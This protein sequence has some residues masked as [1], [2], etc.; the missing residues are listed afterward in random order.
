[1]NGCDHVWGPDTNLIHPSC[2]WISSTTLLLRLKSSQVRADMRGPLNITG[3]LKLLD[4]PDNE[5]R[6]NVKWCWAEVVWRM[7]RHIPRSWS[8]LYFLMRRSKSSKILLRDIF[9]GRFLSFVCTPLDQCNMDK[10]VYLAGSLLPSE[11]IIII[12]KYVYIED[13]HLRLD[14]GFSYPREYGAIALDLLSA[15]YR[16]ITLNTTSNR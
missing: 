5:D 6:K 12:L 7:P 13:S 14:M 15:S 3:I 1:M 9:R 10:Q 2:C 8:M 16:Q 11:L 4:V